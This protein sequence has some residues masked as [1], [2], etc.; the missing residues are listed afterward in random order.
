MVNARTIPR[1]MIGTARALLRP[2]SSSDAR[3]AFEIQSDW[4]VTRMLNASF[5]PSRQAVEDWFSGHESEW[6]AGSAY[7]FAI[8]YQEQTIGI[9]DVD[10]IAGNEGS[11]GYW[12][13]R[14]S[15]GKGL[16]F[17]AAQALIHFAFYEVGLS[18]LTSAHASDNPASGRVL[19]KLGFTQ[20]GNTEILLRSRNETI[21][22]HCYALLP[23][24]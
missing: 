4:D 18:R 9:V 5:P 6:A 21:L 11:L 22:Q 15:W 3:R 12:L 2:T 20:I 14:P 10:S 24:N 8:E 1:S 7:R 16:A 19:T 17:E 23:G 13:E